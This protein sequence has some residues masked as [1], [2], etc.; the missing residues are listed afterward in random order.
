M[1]VDTVRLRSC[2]ISEEL[3][4][5][6]EKESFLRMGV[7]LKT[8]TVAYQITNGELKGSYDSR[9]SIM[10]K[11]KEHVTM[12]QNG[13]DTVVNS[14]VRQ[15][16]ILV[17]C[18]PYLEVEASLHKLF[19]G[20]NIYGGTDDFQFACGY[21]LGTIEQLLDVELPD[22]ETWIVKRIDFSYVFN[23]MS[24]EAVAEF[25]YL[26]KNSYYPRR[27]VNN[28]GLD[29][30][31]FS[32]ST[33]MVK[34]Y[35]K[36]PEFR[37]HDFMRLKKTKFFTESQLF[38]MLELA[39]NLLRVE[40]EIKS[41]KLKYDF[42]ST[43]YGHEPYVKDVTSEYLHNLYAAEVN[44]IMKEGKHKT[45][46][47]RDSLDVENR[48]HAMYD[49]GLAGVLFSVWLKITN[50][51]LERYKA[52][53]SKRTYYRHLKLLKE[54]GV[55]FNLNNDLNS[56]ELTGS[57]ESLV[58]YGF[59]PLAGDDHQMIGE[60]ELIAEAR[61]KFETSE[62]LQRWKKKRKTP[63]IGKDQNKASSNKKTS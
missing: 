2:F 29:G 42:K 35:H 37:T 48:L 25:F 3:A 15:K 51:G 1:A 56:Y 50:F 41:K 16:T 61:E 36:G 23:L 24:P 52:Q 54:C 45:E 38:E 27:K 19:L 63:L 7:D 32:A 46:V 20:H 17:D 57:S 58:P 4:Q 18:D 8:D 14:R 21:L 31:V 39:N 34:F 30:L 60:D 26:M 5:R 22:F 33:S 10:V 53:A 47:V 9:I 62:S 43:R 59:Q 12:T 49:A 40:V 44:R 6:I 13:M 55:S 28:Y 11:R